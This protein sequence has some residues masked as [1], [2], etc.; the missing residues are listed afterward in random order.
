MIAGS[1][2]PTEA[3]FLTIWNSLSFDHSNNIYVSD[4][5]KVML[6]GFIYYEFLKDS[7]NQMTPIGNVKP[8]GENSDRASTLYTTMYSRYNDAVKSSRVIQKYI[9]LN[10]DGYDYDKYNGIQKLFNYWL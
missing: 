3:R 6:K 1:G 4:G 9:D 10:E 5:I 2:T 7:I 8:I